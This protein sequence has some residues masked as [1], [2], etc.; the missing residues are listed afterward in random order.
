MI[1]PATIALIN[2]LEAHD[3]F[4]MICIILKSDCN[5]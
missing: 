4:N 3:I 2:F 5:S 1:V